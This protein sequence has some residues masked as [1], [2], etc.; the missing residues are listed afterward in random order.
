MQALQ[1]LGADA[2]PLRSLADWLLVRSR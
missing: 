2:E 1:P